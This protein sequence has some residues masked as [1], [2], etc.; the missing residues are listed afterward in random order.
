VTRFI[1]YLPARI[2]LAVSKLPKEALN[3]ATEL[4]LRANAPTSLTISGKNRCFNE[5][6]RFCGVD[7]AIRADDKEIAECLSLISRSSMYSFGDTIKQGYIPFGEGCRAGLCGQGIVR[8]GALAGFSRVYGINLR[9]K[10]FIGDYGYEAVRRITEKG[11]RSA[12]VYS[13][14]NKGKTTLLKSIAW[15]LSNGSMGKAYKVAVADERGE[16]FVPEL[17]NGLVDAVC[18]VK[19]TKAMELLCRSMSPEVLICD[20]LSYEDGA[21]LSEYMGT[22]VAV[23]ASIHGQTLEELKS[24]PFVGALL[25]RCAFPLLIGIGD[26]YGYEVEEWVC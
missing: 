5:N 4:R 20:E 24:R 23:I 17:Q 18:G 3:G 8:D 22:G 25:G 7:K 10:R 15:L 11:L 19:K 14:P 21:T 6:G 1:P 12:L 2:G 26:N 9:L 16:L 13:P